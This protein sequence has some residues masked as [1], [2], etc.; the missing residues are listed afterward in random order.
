[1]V[2][3]WTSVRKVAL[4]ARVPGELAE[5]RKLIRTRA[6]WGGRRLRSGR[7]TDTTTAPLSGGDSS[8]VPGLHQE[9]VSS[10]TAALLVV[11]RHGGCRCVSHSIRYPK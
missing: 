5:S 11:Y 3:R 4:D 10:F 8:G 6:S 2:P 1:M 9:F 7:G